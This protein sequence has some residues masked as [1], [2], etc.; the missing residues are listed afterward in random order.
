MFSFPLHITM[1]LSCLLSI[2]PSEWGFLGLLWHTIYIINIGRAVSHFPPHSQSV[3]FLS[4]LP[5][6]INYKACEEFAWPSI[7]KEGKQTIS[8]SCYTLRSV[9]TRCPFLPL[10]WFL[11]S[12]SI[13]LNQSVDLQAHEQKR[14][15][16]YKIPA[17]KLQLKSSKWIYIHVHKLDEPPFYPHPHT[18]TYIALRGWV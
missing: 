7:A 18:H 6:M 5:R 4:S 15:T 3:R 13:I 12:P 8:I 9:Y 2:L 14:G 17:I 1:K 10:S 16:H 11:C